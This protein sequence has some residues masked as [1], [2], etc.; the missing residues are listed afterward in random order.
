[1]PAAAAA[2]FS[3]APDAL[4]RKNLTRTSAGFGFRPIPTSKIA[5]EVSSTVRSCDDRLK[6]PVLG[7]QSSPVVDSGR[8]TGTSAYRFS[9]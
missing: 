9:R 2:C 8:P 1:M 3:V 4:V 6:P 7:G 5:Q